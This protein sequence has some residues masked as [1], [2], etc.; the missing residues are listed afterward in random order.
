M[1]VSGRGDT[2]GFDL[3]DNPN[4][5]RVTLRTGTHLYCLEFGGRQLKFKPDRRWAAKKS[6]A[7][8]ACP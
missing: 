6:P 7:P 1:K 4:P 8:T 5:V 3:N 2:L